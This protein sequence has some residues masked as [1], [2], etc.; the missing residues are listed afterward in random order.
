MEEG[1]MGMTQTHDTFRTELEAGYMSEAGMTKFA[2]EH[3]AEME[4][5]ALHE[6][7][8]CPVCHPPEKG[9]W[10]KDE[11]EPPV[12]YDTDEWDEPGGSCWI[13]DA[14]H[15]AINSRGEGCPACA[16]RGW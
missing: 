5:G 2:A 16:S 15:E 6:G 12:E 14:V 10:W 13:C 1:G 9:Q 7:D 11:P 4:M 3:M 8:C